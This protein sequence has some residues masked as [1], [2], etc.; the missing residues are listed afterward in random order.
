MIY[1]Y[2][3]LTWI[4]DTTGKIH[5]YRRFRKMIIIIVIF[6]ISLPV[7][8]FV[9]LYP[10]KVKMAESIGPKFFVR[11]CVNPG[12]VSG[13]SNFQNFASIKIWFL[14]ILKIHE[15]FLKIREIFFVFDLQ[16][17]QR[18]H[19]HNLIEDGRKAPY[20]PSNYYICISFEEKE[21][22]KI[23]SITKSSSSKV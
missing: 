4:T 15:F 10:I 20:K 11:S 3:S 12:K 6:Y 9:C 16:C 23:M 8:V 19:V 2:C 17:M 5:Y 21:K 1:E 22:I 13:W 14:K 7:W 18:E